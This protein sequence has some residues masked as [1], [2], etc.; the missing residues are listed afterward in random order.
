M[1]LN[2]EPRPVLAICL[3]PAWQ[4][5]LSFRLLRH[6]EVNRAAALRECGGGKG[7]NVVRA[8]RH[9]G[10]P[11]A[12]AVFHGGDS[13]RKLLAELASSGVEALAVATAGQTRT[14]MTLIS[15]ENCEV[16]E[17]IE[18]SA[19]IAPTEVAALRELL[20]R[21][22][23]RFG[24]V[25]LSGT[26]PP[27]VDGQ[28]YAGLAA[29]AR[30]LGIPVVL[31]AVNDIHATLQ[32]GVTVLKINAAELRTIAPSKD[33]LQASAEK[34]L[35]DF[36][37]VMAVAVTDGPA[38]AWLATRKKT[39]RLTVP[40]LPGPLASAIGGGDCATAIMARRLAEQHDKEQLPDIFREALA[41]A[42]ASCLT[43]IPSVF[44]PAIAA[45]LKARIVAEC[46][47]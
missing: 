3:N 38:P 25:T 8:L 37:G 5:I 30:S 2:M 19:P 35:Q 36:P 47:T 29:R 22:L 42:S 33:D 4:K 7:V 9:L 24:A 14:C 27:G 39:W 20:D 31:D 32:T 45:D 13:G 17:L 15:Q 16:T 43:E 6:G 28:F 11:A 21:E 10:L 26:V 46:M 34:V 41:C 44:D 12:V 18:P 1:R 23:A 40:E